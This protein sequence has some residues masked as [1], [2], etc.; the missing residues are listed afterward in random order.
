VGVIDADT[1][2]AERILLVIE[3]LDARSRK[4][5]FILQAR[6]PTFA[7]VLGAFLKC[8]EDFNGGVV[9]K[10]SKDVKAKLD[11]TIKWFTTFF[12][13]PLRVAHDLH[14]Y[15]KMHDRRSYQLLRFTMTPTSDFST[16]H[17]A[18]KELQKRIQSSS[19]APAGLLD[20]LIP[21]IYRSASLIYNRSHQPVYLQ[22]ARTN[23]HGL[24]A[25]ANAVMQEISDKHPEI[26]QA[27]VKELCKIVEEHAPSATKSNDPSSVETLKSLASFARSEKNKMPNDKK[28]IAALMSFASFGTPPKVAKY[29]VCIL[30]AFP[31]RREMYFKDLL[32]KSMTG[33][34]YGSDHFLTKLSTINQLTLLA[35]AITEE[36]TD[37]ILDISRQL[38]LQVRTEKTETDPSWQSDADMDEECQAKSLA[39]KILVTRLRVLEDPETARTLA[40]PVYKLLNALIVKDGEISKDNNTPRHHKARLRLLAAQ[41]MLKVCTIKLFDDILHPTEFNRLSFVAQD[42]IEQIRRGFIEKLQKY[43]VKDH[44]SA[45]FLT[46]IFLT[47]FEPSISFRTSIMTWIR[48]RVKLSHESSKEQSKR[49]FEATFPRLLHLLAHHPD[50]SNDS[51]EL[52]DHAK[53][54]LYYIQTVAAEDNLPLIYKYA[55]RVKQV[56]DAL[57]SS[58]SD[59]VYTL[60]DLAQAVIQKWEEK[61][62]WSMQIWPGKVGMPS[63]LFAALPSHEVA[64]EIADKSYISEDMDPLLDEVVRDVDRKKVRS[65]LVAFTEAANHGT[66]DRSGNL[67]TIQ[68]ILL[69]RNRSPQ[70]PLTRHPR[71]QESGRIDLRRKTRRSHNPSL[72]NLVVT[73]TT[74][75]MRKIWTMHIQIGGT[76][77]AQRIGVGAAEP[78]GRA[79]EHMSK[80]IVIK[81]MRRCGTVSRSGNMKTKGAR[82]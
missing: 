9:E 42:P 7:K 67:P 71:H 45:R 39:I 15:A 80:E 2:R 70:H 4:A 62:G 61:K 10:D 78:K 22:Y 47:A 41:Q 75:M 36:A 63:G 49:L 13:D 50:F 27:S 30:N 3:S 8:C 1:I 53:Y 74:M 17:K 81:M 38:L 52:A 64:Q 66:L 57:P 14:K 19:A 37:E 25:A 58:D 16:V 46:I 56:R 29:A 51:V 79:K 72:G 40:A 21:I 43:L 54:I 32:D 44:L 55:Q 20:T 68:T 31:E 24:G 48:S 76:S 33:W 73:M 11:V 65:H 12:S 6:Q 26:F 23:E 69:R 28:F 34:E 60:S 18:I 5:F 77:R 82:E 35:P 59:N